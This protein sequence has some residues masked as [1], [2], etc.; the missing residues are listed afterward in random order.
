MKLK[1]YKKCSERSVPN[2][3]LSTGFSE[4]NIAIPISQFSAENK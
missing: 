1:K 3:A 4:V 2:F